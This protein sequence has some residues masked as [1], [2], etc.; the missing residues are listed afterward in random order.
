MKRVAR[1]AIIEAWCPRLKGTDW[2]ITSRPAKRYNCIA[3]AAGDTQKR[4]DLGKGN[5]WPRGVEPKYRFACLVQAYIAVGFSVCSTAEGNE[6]DDAFETVVLY[7]RSGAWE[8][9]AKLLRNGMWSSKLGDFEDI[10]HPT[11]EAVGGTDYGEPLIYMRRKR[12][13]RNGKKRASKSV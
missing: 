2:R 3:W 10:E 8:H 6:F 9:A 13:R 5:H 7:E 12:R 11:P 4:W 1:L